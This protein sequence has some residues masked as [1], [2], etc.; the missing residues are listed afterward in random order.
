MSKKFLTNIDLTKNEIQ[1]V[2][3]HKLA[4]APS[5]P[6]SGQV[7]FNTSDERY[8]I[9]QSSGW[10]DITGRLDDILSNTNAI[11]LTDN[12]DGTIN[13]EI[14]NASSSNAGL[15]S[16]THYNDVNNATDS[17]TASTL[18]KRDAN[19][20]FSAHNITANSI[21]ITE[22]I[23]GSTPLNHAATKGYVDNLFSTGT[24]IKGSIDC[25]SNPNYPAADSGD[26]YYVSASGRIGGS[27][28]QLVNVGD[29]LVALVDTPAGNEA[30]VG[31]NWLIVEHNIDYATESTAGIIEI[32][33]QSEVN[34]GTDDTKA[35]TPLKL[36]TYV[37][38]QISGNYYATD[39]GDG[40]ATSF[41][42]NHGLNNTDVQVQ[43]KD[44]TTLELVETDIT[45]TNS[46]QIT[47]TFAVAPA[48]NA[49]RVILQ[50]S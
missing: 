8:Y 49:Y 39:I 7:Y 46:N 26:I 28:G 42:V 21:V 17:S 2:V 9:Y 37:T 25:S 18:V 14:A 36:V 38:S 12:G 23:S 15:M 30:T 13:I 4:T 24:R 10:K 6:T 43:I 16:T 11:T 35:I 41:V 32:A 22:T 20:D 19:S 47:I 27:S 34:T 45:I 5:S 29:M 3:I 33:T 40:S 1:N 31:S 50:S 44:T 48:S